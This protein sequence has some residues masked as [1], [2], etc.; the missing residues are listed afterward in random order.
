MSMTLLLK[1]NINIIITHLILFRD[2]R[3]HQGV[4]V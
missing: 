3:T 4:K 2:L 1:E